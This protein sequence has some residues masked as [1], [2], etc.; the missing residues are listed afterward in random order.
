[1]KIWIKT[2]LIA[3]KLRMEWSF[4]LSLS[5]GMR[6]M[7]GR[8]GDHHWKAWM[9]TARNQQNSADILGNMAAN[10][11]SLDLTNTGRPPCIILIA[12]FRLPTDPFKNIF[13]CFPPRE[14]LKVTKLSLSSL[15]G[16]VQSISL[17]D[18]RPS[19]TRRIYRLTVSSWLELRVCQ[20]IP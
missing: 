5:E 9:R 1:M 19:L 6:N 4:S 15:V 10:E 17:N 3:R 16:N 18:S 2:S 20:F 14:S 11:H 8:S 12:N 13:F 7:E